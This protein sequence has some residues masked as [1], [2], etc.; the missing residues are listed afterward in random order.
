M[1]QQTTIKQE[2]SQ[3][4]VSDKLPQHGRDHSLKK[5]VEIEVLGA[6]VNDYLS[7]DERNLAAVG[8]TVG[9]GPAPEAY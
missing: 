8:E 2:S 6:Y 1:C 3:I 9:G 5:V 4:S 7:I